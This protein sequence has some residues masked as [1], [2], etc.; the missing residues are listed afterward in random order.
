MLTNPAPLSNLRFHTNKFL[1]FW[2]YMI[3]VNFWPPFERID[4]SGCAIDNSVSCET[5]FV[6]YET[7]WYINLMRIWTLLSSYID[8]TK[9]ILNKILVCDRSTAL[10]LNKHDKY[11]LQSLFVFD[12]KWKPKCSNGAFI[13]TTSYSSI[14]SFGFKLWPSSI[15]IA[16]SPWYIFL[17]LLIFTS[18]RS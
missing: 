11:F 5:C 8:P 10:R 1:L 9:L 18:S 12:Y 13:Y 15:N 6:L 14:L 4:L 2:S 3:M 7:S 16:Y 17:K